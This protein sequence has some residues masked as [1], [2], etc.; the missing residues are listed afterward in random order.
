MAERIIAYRDEHG[1]FTSVDELKQV[2]GIGPALF[3]KIAPLVRV[4]S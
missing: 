4:G 1:P 2:K 3:A